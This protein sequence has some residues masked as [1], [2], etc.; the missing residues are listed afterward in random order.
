MAAINFPTA[1]SN[2]QTFTADTGVIYTYIGTPPN[3]FWSGTFGTTGLATLDGRFVALNDGNSI[4]T[5][6][7]QG[8]K[9]NNGSADTILLDA[10]N[11]KVGIGTT[12]PS[13]KLHIASTAAGGDVHITNASGQNCLLEIAGNG[14]TIGSGSALY[15]QD[16][17][18]NVY[19]GFARGAHPVLLGTSGAE[20][21]RITPAGNVAIGT[22]SASHQLT[23]HNAS[24]TGGTIEAN[25]FSVRNNYGSV[26]GL[27]NGFVSPANNSLA[28]ATNSTERMRIDS[29]GKVGIGGSPTYMLDVQG[30]DAAL[31]IKGTSQTGFIADQAT[32]GLVSLIN[33]D[34][35]A[36]LR[37]GTASTERM[38]IDSSGNVIFKRGADVGN[39]L[40][41]TGADTTSETLEIGIASGGGNAQLT[42]TNAAG[43]S[44]SCGLIFRTRGTSGT[45]ERMR[46]DST[47]VVGIGMTPGT[48]ASST[49]MLQLYA[50]SQCFISIGNATSGSGP[51][52]G[53]TIGNDPNSAYLW[54]REATPIKFATNNSERMQIDSSGNVRIGQT[55]G[56]SSKLSLYG[57]QLRFQGASTGTG[58]GDGFGIGNNG[59]TDSF[60]WNYENGFIQFGTN[61]TEKARLTTGGY[62]HAA[63]NGVFYGNVNPG[64]HSFTQSGVA[65]WIA[66]FNHVNN[67][68]PYGIVINYGSYAPNNTSSHFI[69]CSDTSAPRFYVMSNGG[70]RNYSAYN[71]S[72]SDEREKKNIVSMDTKWDKVKSW[73]LKKFHFNEN[74]DTDDLHY[75]IIAQQIEPECPEVVTDWEK[76]PAKEA[77]LDEAGNVIKPAEDAVMRKAVKEQQ[78]MWM[79]IKVLQEAQGRIETLES[80]DGPFTVKQPTALLNNPFASFL[81]SNGDTAGSIIQNGINSVTYA[82]SSDYR[83]KD[84][85]VNLSAA[86][87][88]LK[89]LAPKRFNFKADADVT[90]DGFL[91]HEAQVVVPE[92]VTGTHNQLDGNGNAIYQGIDQSKLVPLLTAALQEAI[93]RIETLETEVAA[94][95]AG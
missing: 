73:E 89:Q 44:N 94:L 46:I 38:R 24:T 22:T 53:V 34:S 62:F 39:I 55:S 57:S 40:Q 48:D 37:F 27:G 66:G 25:R 6:Q 72:L 1:T 21:M 43:G 16:A 8:L 26:S 10:V 67:S 81:N 54:N 93:G 63:N 47:G 87:P 18:N 95:K 3:G 80:D 13:T 19:A 49:Y 28:I 15:G 17:S 77:E 85:V 92:A 4:Q 60:I 51:N 90:V 35:G 7:T 64:F 70:I 83:L 88:R 41:I 76:A 75:G 29:S 78:M 42:A 12:S 52:N 50:S 36:S 33:Y 20:R 69:Y 74:K 11:S 58:E 56:S 68:A 65:Q 5:M 71:N 30:T 59:A 32:S 9:F 23:V 79:S 2:G 45:A 86:I 61:N 14:N 84:N 91:A 31:R 82:T